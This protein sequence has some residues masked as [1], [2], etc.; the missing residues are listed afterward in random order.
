M[1]VWTTF[2][3]EI[4]LV[5]RGAASLLHMSAGSLRRRAIDRFFD[6]NRKQLFSSLDHAARG[7][8]DEFTAVLRPRERRPVV[9]VVRLE[10]DPLNPALALWTFTAVPLALDAGSDVAGARPAPIAPST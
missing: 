2:T 5:S 10:Q 4:A 8:T 9:M 3:G 6:G 1:R 7:Y